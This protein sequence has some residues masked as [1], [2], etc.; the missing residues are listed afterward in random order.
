MVIATRFPS[1]LIPHP[2]KVV[3]LIHQFR[4]AYDLLGTPYSD[5]QDNPEDRAAARMIHRM[6]DK[7]FAEARA[8]YTISLNTAA[9]LKKYN[10]L[11]ATAL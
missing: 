2:N 4:Q 6:D 9:R 10:G 1:Y 11:D 3:W 7:A 8:V 5:F